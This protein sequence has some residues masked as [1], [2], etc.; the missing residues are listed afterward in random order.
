MWKQAGTVVSE[1]HVPKAPLE[2][3]DGQNKAVR[4]PDLAK[5][6]AKEWSER[7]SHTD[8]SDRKPDQ[9][10][11]HTDDRTPFKELVAVLDALNATQRDLKMPDGSASKVPAFNPT[12]A[13]R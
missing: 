6:I 1:I 13:V 11:L 9:A 12:F 5:A 8:P 7:G 3:G 2:V 4:Y 10:I